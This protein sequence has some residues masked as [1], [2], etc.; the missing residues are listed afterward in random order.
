M[1]IVNRSMNLL[2]AMSVTI[3]STCPLLAYNGPSSSSADTT[4]L[5]DDLVHIS[6]GENCLVDLNPDIIVEGYEGDFSDFEMEV[7]DENGFPAN[8]PISRAYLGDTLYLT[9]IHVPSGK[10]CWGRALIQDK[11]APQIT[12]SNSVFECYQSAGSF[13]RPIA[14]DNCDFSPSVILL[15]ENIDDS[16]LC[17]GVTVTRTYMAVDDFGNESSPCTSILTST[18]LLLPTLPRDTFWSCD[19]YNSRPSVVLPTRYGSGVPNVSLGS[20]CPYNVVHSDNVT[21]N[22]CGGDF[23][24]IRTWTVI[25]W[26]TNEIITTGA[27]GNDNIQVITVKDN[28]PPVI[29]RDSFVVNANLGSGA[30][31]EC[32]STD[33]L[34]PASISD[35]CNATTVRILTSIGEAIYVNGQDGAQGGFIPSPGLPL[36]ADTIVYEA[37]D[38]CGNTS[39]LRVPIKIVDQTAPVTVCDELTNVTLG[40]TGRAVIAAQVFDDGSHDN[41]CLDRFEVRRMD[42]ICTP[43][44]TVLKDS[45]I[46]CCMDVGDTVQV[47]FRAIDCAGNFNECMVLVEVEEKLPPSLEH[48]PGDVTI[49]CE[50]Y[51]NNLELALTSGGDSV[52]D[53]FGLPVFKDNCDLVYLE[54]SV[55]LNLDQ[56]QQGDIL[57]RWRVTDPGQNGTL[58]CEQRIFIEHFSD[59]AVEFPEDK[60][61]ICGEDFPDTGEPEIFYETCELVAISHSDEIFTT[62]PDVCYKIARTWIVINWCA[63]ADPIQEIVVESSEYDLDFDLNGDGEKNKRSFQDGLAISNFSENAF[64]HGANP[65]GYIVYQQTIKVVDNV[66]PVVNCLPT[67]EICIGD[68]TCLADFVLPQPDIMDCGTSLSITAS[69]DLGD[70]L[71]PFVN[72]PPG[73]YEMTYTVDDNCGNRGFCTTAVEVRDCKKPTPYCKEGFI[74]E[75][76]E[77][78]VIVIGP[79]IFDAGS[80]DNCPGEL[81]FSFSADLADT[82]KVYDC[83]FIG[84]R[85]VVVWVTDAAGNQDFCIT[86]VDVQ[87]NNGVCSGDPLIAGTVGTVNDEPVAGAT[88]TLNGSMGSELTTE[89]AGDFDFSV[90]YGGDYTLASEKNGDPLNGVTTYDLV[91]ISKHVLGVAVFDNPY[92]IIAADANLS[93]SVTTYDIVALRKLILQ[94][95]TELPSGLSWRFIDAKHSFPNPLLPFENPLPET[96]NYNNVESDM[97]EADFIAIK[98]GDV[99]FSADPQ[100]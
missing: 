87:D 72:V 47:V 62:V 13:P 58:L 84:F 69:G 8:L 95:E 98:I 26:C 46:F 31:E 68:T 81:T 14:T 59:W 5:C 33:F 15:S 12:C 76:D 64:L 41:C 24:I 34:L 74:I 9:A 60:L 42:N 65:D 22:S 2:L 86:F 73:I 52:L 71:G 91:M 55:S 50:F 30:N 17:G 29:S 57:R 94:V 19:V 44:D 39:S 56:C 3:A 85:T 4:F 75:L 21:E 92:Q 35:N 37:V 6:L 18:P 63:V 100:Q 79:E 93:N 49:D 32:G 61:V 45:V 90:H 40:I 25:N 27:N 89:E 43:L 67:T 88:V 7:L 99:N 20:F 70:G 82:I 83:G 36:G 51:T 16:D 54:N 28:K 97:M 96:L 66:A 53:Q 23:T 11:W 80:F 10:S 77:D 78:S 38:A 48:C 1:K